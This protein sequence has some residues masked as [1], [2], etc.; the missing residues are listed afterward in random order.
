[1]QTGI[2]QSSAMDSSLIRVSATKSTLNFHMIDLAP[3]SQGWLRAPLLSSVPLQQNYS[4]LLQN[5]DLDRQFSVCKPLLLISK[6]AVKEIRHAGE[7]SFSLIVG[8]LV[9]F[10]WLSSGSV[11]VRAGSRR[12]MPDEELE[13]IDVVVSGIAEEKK[14]RRT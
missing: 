5:V 9:F 4:Y 3:L 11:Q 2:N 8:F 7:D 12:S 13:N 6:P 10:F 1:M 14:I